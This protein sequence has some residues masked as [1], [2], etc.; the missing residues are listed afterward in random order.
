M[1][2]SM[3]IK[4]SPMWPSYSFNKEM[5]VIQTTEPKFTNNAGT[6]ALRPSFKTDISNLF[7]GTAYVKETIDIFSMEA[8]TIGGKCVANAID[9]RSL[10][11]IMLARPIIFSPFRIL[12]NVSYELGFPNLSGIILIIII[13]IIMLWLINKL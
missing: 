8:A 9:K 10:P 2:K 1:E 5:D 4:W 6:Y 12:D 11:P 13:V 7:I 3:V